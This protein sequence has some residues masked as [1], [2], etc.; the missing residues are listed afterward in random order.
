MTLGF[1]YQNHCLAA[2]ATLEGGAS[3]FVDFARNLYAQGDP[4]GELGPV[5]D[6]RP[7]RRYRGENLGLLQILVFDF[8]AAKPVDLVAL[9]GLN[10]TPAGWVELAVSNDP[11]FAAT[12]WQ[13]GATPDSRRASL[14]MALPDGISARY[15]RVG[16]CDPTRD[17]LEL[18]LA[19]AGEL[20]RPRYDAA[21]GGQRG[22]QDASQ[23]TPAQELG[24]A[25]ARRV[26]RRQWT[27]PFAVIDQADI[28]QI[29]ADLGGGN[30]LSLPVLC[31]ESSPLAGGLYSG[32]WIYGLL[33]QG[34]VV[35][36][37]F[38]EHWSG[39]LQILEL[40]AR[41]GSGEGELVA[42]TLALDRTGAVDFT[43]A[44]P[45]L[46]GQT[47]DLSVSLRAAAENLKSESGSVAVAGGAFGLVGDGGFTLAPGQSQ[48][49]AVRFTPTIQASDQ[50][51]SLTVTHSASGTV[52]PLS[53]ALSGAALAPPVFARLHK[54]YTATGPLN[55]VGGSGN[56]GARCDLILSGHA[57]P[58]AYTAAPDLTIATAKSYFELL[59]EALGAGTAGQRLQ[60]GFARAARSSKLTLYA[61]GYQ[62]N[63]D[64][65]FTD[66]GKSYVDG[67]LSPLTAA[68]AVGDVV[69]VALDP[70][71]RQAWIGVNG[72]WLA[73][74]DPPAGLNPT[75]SWAADPDSEIR[76]AASL[77]KLGTRVTFNFGASP[78]FY[79]PP[80][81]WLA[82]YGSNL[83]NL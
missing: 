11:T 24:V 65:G 60:V 73:S 62:N 58:R 71:A 38:K 23:V 44:E 2:E 76:A 15:L 17:Y 52:S 16:L 50:A 83:E 26:P 3:C 39:S 72:V 42:S 4:D 56:L 69:M 82:G 36:N 55:F 54:D 28:D 14:I 6:F 43:P 77:F 68:L 10:L 64:W 78:F 61:L 74:G 20:A 41:P 29:F 18:G 19:I 80:A 8:G 5:T 51:G 25:V 9:L 13:A 30:G 75:F 67:V 79:A 32:D 33:S 63:L 81:G 27:V 12:L 7:T 34:V 21:S 31:L 48:A 46:I 40:P 70:A 1:L 45:L 35:R 57:W 22:W 59:V 47:A 37:L 53:I 49:F 66:A